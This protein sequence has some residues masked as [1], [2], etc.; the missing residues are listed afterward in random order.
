MLYR[1]YIHKS[2]AATGSA[3][4]IYSVNAAISTNSEREWKGNCA[5]DYMDHFNA[6][7]IKSLIQNELGDKCKVMICYPPRKYKQKEYI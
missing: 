1:L 6:A 4:A 7:E 5:A 2:T 3:P